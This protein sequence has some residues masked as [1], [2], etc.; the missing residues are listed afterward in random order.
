[1]AQHL[2]KRFVDHRGIGLAA[3]GVAKLPLH[4]AKCGLDVRALV[5]V[6]QEL[7]FAKHEVMEHLL[8]RSASFTRCR[9]LERDKWGAASLRDHIGVG[10][11][12]VSLISRNLRDGKVLRGRFHHRGKRQRIVR[13]HLLNVDSGYDVGFNSA[14]EMALNPILLD[15]LF[16]ILHIMPA[17]K[18]RGCKAGRIDREAGF[19][20]A[21]RQTAL[22][23]KAA[24]NGG[25]GRV[26]KVIENRV[27]MRSGSDEA[28]ALRVP[29]IAHKATTA[30]RRIDLEHYAEDGI[31]QGQLRASRPA[32]FRG[33][34]SMAEIEKQ[35]QEL[36]LFVRLRGVVSGPRLRVGRSLLRES[37]SFRHRSASVS[38]MLA[39]H[40]ID[41][42][43]DV[44]AV[45]AAGLVVGA[46]ALWIGFCQMPDR[47]DTLPALRRHN[48]AI[49][50][51]LNPLCG[52]QYDSA[53]LSQVFHNHLAY[54]R[55]ILLIRYIFVKEII[56]KIYL[57]SISVSGI[58]SRSWGRS[59]E[60]RVG[61]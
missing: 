4:H 59:E 22:L 2:T 43:V 17:G 55:D 28:L 45:L 27:V 39:P 15:V 14:H 7:L 42:G 60:R 23:D 49:A 33:C 29:Q 1:M 16:A 35:A 37:Y 26:F 8:E 52:R 11:A 32:I 3:Q 47:I 48:P 25:H 40:Y 24:Q 31:R 20:A 6:L 10:Q 34:D 41:R 21:E 38:V 9:P 36:I 19:H 58:S 51:L 13:V 5:V 53:L 46:G 18:P 57:D 50:E 44:F 30:H 61:K 12:T 54:L 56:V